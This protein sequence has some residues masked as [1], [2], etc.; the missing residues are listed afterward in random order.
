MFQAERGT[1]HEWPLFKVG[2]YMAENSAPASSVAA[3]HR[4][5]E[6]G[7]TQVAERV[8]ELLPELA[9]FLGEAAVALVGGLQPSKERGVGGPLA[10]W[11]GNSGGP[12]LFR[13]QPAS[14]AKA[15]RPKLDL[16]MQLLRE[17]DT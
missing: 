14:G 7:G 15:S 12:L 5:L 6:P 13:P 10:G 8:G 3:S 4:G 17:G 9:I 2:A 11:H 16:V 1:G